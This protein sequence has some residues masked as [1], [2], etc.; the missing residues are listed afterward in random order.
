MNSSDQARE[1][2]L[3]RLLQ[4]A[5]KAFAA[6]N[7]LDA[8][9]LYIEVLKSHPNHALALQRR[10]RLSYLMGHHGGAAEFLRRSLAS[11]PQ[12]PEA[13][14]S[15]AELYR[16]LGRPDLAREAYNNLTSL[17]P[18]I[19][20]GHTQTGIQDIFDG[21]P[22]KGLAGLRKGLELDPE[23]GLAMLALARAGS[24]AVDDPAVA[25]MEALFDKQTV[26]L[27]SRLEAGF[28][29]AEVALSAGDKAGYWDWLVKV[30]ALQRASIDGGIVEVAALF[31]D[32]RRSLDD[33]FLDNARAPA[34][35]A[36]FT[37]IFIVGV[38]RSGAWLLEDHLA[39]HPQITAG[40]SPFFLEQRIVVA[41]ASVTRTLYPGAARALTAERRTHLARE[42]YRLMLDQQLG[43]RFIVDSNADNM[44]HIG[45]IKL[46]FPEAKVIHI[47]RDP[48]AAGFSAFRHFLRGNQVYECDFE[49][50][51]NYHRLVGELMDHWR[52]V[53][54]GFVT[55]ISYEDLVADPQG[56][57]SP[58]FDSL[59]LTAGAECHEPGPSLRGRRAE[60]LFQSREAAA[61]EATVD[62][63]DF[64]DG[65]APLSAALSA[66]KP[67]FLIG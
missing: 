61:G 58:V 2:P 52:T 54:P 46:L 55:D 53:C 8:E 5:E 28:A 57:L 7:H 48:M 49:D 64:E 21:D 3:L 15:V 13:W 36:P 11:A 9:R 33:R 22:D 29:R 37:P 42:Y 1:M 65:L 14:A 6:G 20:L 26:P 31:D 16:A 24:L 67:G 66:E 45:L 43:G 56:A 62:W 19:A 4:R 35:Q 50:F 44:K 59:G 25:L 17:F 51:A 32:I 39:R 63:H 18:D 10:A 41:A 23:S 38:P 60:N 40:G 34:L 47:S 27:Q 30:N 12:Q